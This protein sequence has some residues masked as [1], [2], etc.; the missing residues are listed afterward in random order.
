[1]TKLEKVIMENFAKR[2][3]LEIDHFEENRAVLTE[4][5]QRH[6]GAKYLM[7]MIEIEFPDTI[8]LVVR[9]ED[10]TIHNGSGPAWERYW[11]D[12]VAFTTWVA[13]TIWLENDQVHR[14]DGP[15]LIKADGTE[16]W[17]CHGR[18]HRDDGLPAVIKPDGTREYYVNG[19]Q[20]RVEAPEERKDA[21]D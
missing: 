20:I 4:E 15:A 8:T 19:V 9:K 18:I 14:N 5:S 7:W 3:G 17:F 6:T 2:Y 1:M 10:R 12:A 11:H 21:L 16:M 13:C